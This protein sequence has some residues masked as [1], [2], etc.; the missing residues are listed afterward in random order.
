M[1]TPLTDL[2]PAKVRTYL[3]LTYALLGLLLGA[4]PVYCGATD[5]GTPTPVIGALAVYTFLGGPLFG[6]LAVSNVKR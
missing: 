2:L 3:Y 4:V 6:A 5:T 1:T